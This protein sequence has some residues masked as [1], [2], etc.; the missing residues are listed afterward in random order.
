MFFP[1]EQPPVRNPMLLESGMVDYDWERWFE[2]IRELLRAVAV[3]E[4]DWTPVAVAANSVVE[5]T[6][7]VPGARPDMAIFVT[8]PGTTAGIGSA[9]VSAKDTVAVQF[10]NPTA[11]SLTPPAGTYKFFGVRP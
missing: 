5:Q 7:T 3:Q 4:V 11:G 10:I 9:R 6:V 1:L 8:P 2:R